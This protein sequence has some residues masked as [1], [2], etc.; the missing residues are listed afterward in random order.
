MKVFRSFRLDAANQCLW[1]GEQRV[2]LAPKVFDVLRYLV[3]HPGRLITQNELLEALWPDTYVNPELIK[4]Y[5]LGIRKVL[6]DQHDKPIFIE[7]L[8]KRGYQFVA[9]VTESVATGLQETSP[10]ISSK[11]VGREDAL[12]VLDGAFSKIVRSHR[13]L[14]FVTGEPGIGKTTLVDTFQQRASHHRN[15]RIARGHCVEGFGG[16]EPYYPMLDALGQ[17]TRTADGNPVVQALSKRA[18]T[19]FV[20]FPS[21]I[22]TDQKEGL[23]REIL[24]ATRE[25]MLREICEALESLSS[26]MTLV[27]IFEDLHWVDPSTLDL[28]SVLARRREPAKLMLICT[29]RPL[30]VILSKS[31]L[32]GLKQDL[33]VHQLCTEIALE[34]LSEPA[35]AEYLTNVF[36]S[37]DLPSGVANLVYRH[38]GGNALFM[39]AII[40]DMIKKGL[41][42]QVAGQWKLSKDLEAIDLGVPETLQQMLELQFEKF[43]AAEQSV[44]AVGS[45]V[46]EHFSVKTIS[47]AL[48]EKP[49]YI[50]DLCDQLAA[51]QQLIKSTGIEEFSNGLTS[52]NYEFGHSLYRQAI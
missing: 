47:T 35:I 37:P 38:S 10:E 4:K 28:I 40:Q 27:L 44:L 18:P 39:A 21:L 33:Q 17:L 34:R 2:A 19:W 45:V 46:G 30:E 52:A 15:I 32:K 20:Q 24:G 11:M 5:I 31:G 25:R 14:I 8:P 16:R 13:Q 42:A 7:T 3:E 1:R 26:E 43:S 36:Q 9:P 48:N 6:G 49:E 12:G 51:R 29:Y 22:R 23:Q 41:I 50:E